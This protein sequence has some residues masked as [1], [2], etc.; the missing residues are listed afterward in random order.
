MMSSMIYS[1]L[2]AVPGPIAGAGAG[3]TG[4][5]AQVAAADYDLDTFYA[6]SGGGNAGAYCY[7][8]E[9]GVGAYQ[10]YGTP[11]IAAHTADT[12]NADSWTTTGV[13][14]NLGVKTSNAG[15]VSCFSGGD[16]TPGCDKSGKTVGECNH[17]TDGNRASQLKIYTDASV[18]EPK[19]VVVEPTACYYEITLTINPGA[20]NGG[21]GAG[22]G[23]G[24]GEEADGK[25]KGGG[26][27]DDDD[28]APTDPTLK[29]EFE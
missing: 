6:I 9:G 2:L 10:R 19:I 3:P 17:I 13:Q 26:G 29:G 14:V 20:I 12:C 24:D 7:K 11:S 15:L 27:D 22:G 28:D 1:L 8:L 4:G 5:P 18:T 16:T 21:D 23:S 25:G